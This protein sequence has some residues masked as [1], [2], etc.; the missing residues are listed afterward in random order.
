MRASGTVT[1]RRR[2]I[3]IPNALGARPRRVLGGI[4]AR[5]LRQLTLGVLLGAVAT[6]FLDRFAGGEILH[7]HALTLL[8]LIVILMIGVGLLAALGPARRGLRIQPAEALRGE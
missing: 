2:E 3:G 5:A 8:P 7:G 6:M 4:F 1:Q